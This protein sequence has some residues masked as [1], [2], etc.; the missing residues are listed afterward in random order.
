[1]HIGRRNLKS[2]PSPR[3]NFCSQCQRDH[4]SA[5]DPKLPAYFAGFSQRASG[6]PG[7]GAGAGAEAA[8][9]A[10]A[11]AAEAPAPG[12]LHVP[13]R[14]MPY[15]AYLLL[16]YL[17]LVLANT[18][19]MIS[20]TAMLLLLTL[21]YRRVGTAWLL[22]LWPPIYG[23]DPL[24]N[25]TLAVVYTWLLLPRGLQPGARSGALWITAQ[26]SRQLAG[27]GCHG[28]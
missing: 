15:S 21:A 13:R 9:A 4:L 3:C 1:M 2:P 18:P 28:A 12:L 8:A 6:K 24:V 26:L 14:R 25:A 17:L 20:W 10:A 23:V 19:Q 7:H 27:P 5:E 22:L 16:Q 11:D